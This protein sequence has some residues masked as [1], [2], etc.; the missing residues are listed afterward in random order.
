MGIQSSSLCISL[1]G[2]GLKPALSESVRGEGETYSNDSPH[3]IS[4]PQGARGLPKKKESLLY[5]KKGL[6]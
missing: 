2:R 1:E 6:F 4:L 5:V 3:S